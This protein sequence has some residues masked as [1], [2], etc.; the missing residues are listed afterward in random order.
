MVYRDYYSL[1]HVT[2]AP[3]QKELAYLSSKKEKVFIITGVKTTEAEKTHS[4]KQETK[5]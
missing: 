1:G 5:L 4:D 3:S 2:V